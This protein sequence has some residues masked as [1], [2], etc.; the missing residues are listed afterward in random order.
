MGKMEKRGE[1]EKK[2]HL[3]KHS[4]S[5]AKWGQIDKSEGVLNEK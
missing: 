5:E 4:K 2:F 3:K 1:G